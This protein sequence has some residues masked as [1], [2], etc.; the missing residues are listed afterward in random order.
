MGRI[1]HWVGMPPSG[2]SIPYLTTRDVVIPNP[3]DDVA[4]LSFEMKLLVMVIMR[5][6]GKRTGFPVPLR[7]VGIVYP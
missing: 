6:V 4:D 5:L 3:V 2:F 1:T 7:L